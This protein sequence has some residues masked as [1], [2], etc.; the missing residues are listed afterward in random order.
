MLQWRSWC[1]SG[2]HG[3]LVEVMVLQWR[4]W[5]FSGGHGALVEVIVLQW[6]SRCFSGG[7]GASVRI[8]ESAEGDLDFRLGYDVLAEEPE[9]VNGQ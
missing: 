4:S 8:R 3:A 1:F 5:C 9:R 7:H 6:R 2:G